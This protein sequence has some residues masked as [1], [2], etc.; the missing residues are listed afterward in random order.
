MELA[1]IIIQALG[2][3]LAAIS[4]IVVATWFINKNITDKLEKQGNCF[5]AEFELIKEH[6]HKHNIDLIES[7]KHN[8]NKFNEIKI[9]FMQEKDRILKDRAVII[10]EIW[11]NVNSNENTIK[12]VENQIMNIEN[13]FN[14]IITTQV[15]MENKID[16][17]YNKFNEVTKYLR[18]L[19]EKK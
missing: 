16:D 15:K 8:D 13:K 4:S 2:V 14:A 18:T 19:I 6:S 3:V 17:L 10:D 5:K 12:I 11:D 7:Q 9:E 1:N